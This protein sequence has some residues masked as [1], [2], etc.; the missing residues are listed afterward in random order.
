MDGW[1][2]GGGVV[3]SSFVR[4]I[5][6]SPRT[7]ETFSR[8][9]CRHPANVNHAVQ[10]VGAKPQSSHRTPNGAARTQT[11]FLWRVGFGHLGCMKSVR[12][13]LWLA[14]FTVWWTCSLVR[15]PA[16][17]SRPHQSWDQQFVRWHSDINPQGRS[18]D[19]FLVHDV[20]HIGN[21]HFLEPG[22]SHKP[23]AD[24]NITGL[25]VRSIYGVFLMPRLD[26]QIHGITYLLLHLYS[27]TFARNNCM[28]SEKKSNVARA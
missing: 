11:P 21:I 23:Q 9:Q 17:C 22:T 16:L 15:A 10:W 20:I 7:P 5:A 24:A 18:S 19:I 4:P 3:G 2:D 26:A 6:S 28:S 12:L 27:L 25:S 1:V 13:F 8:T 14:L